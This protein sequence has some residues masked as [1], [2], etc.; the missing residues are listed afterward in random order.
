MRV[1]AFPK[2]R[3]ITL[4]I[5][6]G[7]VYASVLAQLFHTWWTDENYSHGLLIPFVIAYVLWTQR[8]RLGRT[9]PNPSA[10]W[11]GFLVLLGL[12][13]LWVGVAGAELYAQRMSL[14]VTICGLILFCYG[15]A[16]LRIAWIAL[17]FLVL[18]IPIPAIIFNQIAFP[19]QL[20]ASRCAVWGMRLFEVPVLRQGNVIEIVPLNSAQTKKLEVVEACSGIRS[21]MTLITLAVVVAY[22]SYYRTSS[23]HNASNGSEHRWS[24]VRAMWKPALIISAAIP[25]AI[26]T[27]AFRVSGTGLLAHYYGTQVADGFFHYFSGWLVYLVALLLLFAFTWCLD[28]VALIDS[29]TRAPEPQPLVMSAVSVASTPAGGRR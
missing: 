15:P 23:Q 22:V 8:D 4:A 7:F 13:V 3:L 14:V 11:G 12:F 18:A 24:R 28:R 19:L 26:L 27:N 20:F 21:L 10:W 9:S 25:I 29:R 16:L 6:T 17:A 5:A 1:S 2:P